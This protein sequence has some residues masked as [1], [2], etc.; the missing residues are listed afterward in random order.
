MCVCVCGMCR[1]EGEDDE[2][3][4]ESLEGLLPQSEQSQSSRPP[5]VCA[6]GRAGPGMFRAPEVSVPREKLLLGGRWKPPPVPPGVLARLMLSRRRDL[7]GGE[8]S[9]RE[10][11]L[12]ECEEYPESEMMSGSAAEMD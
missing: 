5:R 12:A 8:A 4:E 6:R 9:S 7:G 2:G 1:A 11:V 3:E 10:G